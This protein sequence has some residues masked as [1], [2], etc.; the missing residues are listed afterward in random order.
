MVTLNMEGSFDLNET[1]I[2]AKVTRK[3]AGNYALGKI[4]KNGGLT[5]SYVGRSDSDVN[6]RLKYWAE[7]STHKKFKFSYAAS[8]KEAFEKECQNYHDF[9]PPE[10]DIHPDKPDGS[11]LKCPVCGK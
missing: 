8:S 2:D 11:N 10:N 6:D 3:S 5:V 4:N 1:T 9:N 7:N